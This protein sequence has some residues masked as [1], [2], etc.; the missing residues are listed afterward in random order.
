[1]SVPLFPSEF[2]ANLLEL[3]ERKVHND[4]GDWSAKLSYDDMPVQIQ[5]PWLKNLF[6]VSCYNAHSNQ[7]KSYSMSFELSDDPD[8]VSFKEFLLQ[9]D[10]WF[11][12]KFTEIELKGEYFSSVRPPNKSHLPP[13]LRTKLKVKGQNFDLMYLD[14]AFAKKWPVDSEFIQHGDKCRCILELL[15]V[16]SAGGRVGTSWKIVTLQKM[17]PPTFR[18]VKTE[19]PSQQ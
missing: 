2:D 17:A 13:L 11:K 5:T 12:E 7:R 14:S 10:V 18:T 19:D 6:G 3:G 16:W 9:L 4:N 15:P 1:M 8:I